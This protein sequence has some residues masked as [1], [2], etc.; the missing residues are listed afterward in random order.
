MDS[1]Q[2]HRRTGAGG[3]K[4]LGEEIIK[5]TKVTNIPGSLIAM[6]L[7]KDLSIPTYPKSTT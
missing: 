7:I 5:V 3:W 4:K 2:R 1:P 6:F